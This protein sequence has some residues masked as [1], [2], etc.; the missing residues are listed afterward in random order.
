MHCDITPICGQNAH[1]DAVYGT[2][3]N[4]VACFL[5]GDRSRNRT[6]EVSEIN[7]R[8]QILFNP[9]AVI[10]NDYR[11][12]NI[13]N[14]QGVT[15]LAETVTVVRVEDNWHPKRGLVLRQAFVEAR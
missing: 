12:S 14:H 9:E 3:V 10:A 4:S 1:G 8:F 15:V 13:V 5:F 11:V 7:P 2:T 6:A